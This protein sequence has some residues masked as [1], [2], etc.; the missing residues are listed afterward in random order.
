[1]DFE[2]LSIDSLTDILLQTPIA[3]LTQLC[4]TNK[5]VQEICFSDSFW[6]K[7]LA[8]DFPNEVA[9]KPANLSWKD[10]YINVSEFKIDFLKLEYEDSREEYLLE[11]VIPEIFKQLRI[12]EK[13]SIDPPKI[14]F[15]G[16][17]DSNQTTFER[18]SNHLE[19]GVVSSSKFVALILLRFVR[20]IIDDHQTMLDEDLFSRHYDLGE[21]KRKLITEEEFNKIPIPISEFLELLSHHEDQ[22]LSSFDLSDEFKVKLGYGKNKQVIRK[23][24][25]EVNIWT[26]PRIEQ[27]FSEDI[28]WR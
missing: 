11:K 16:E 21:E 27:A 4:T 17:G 7:R 25:H 24:L 14:Y 18:A 23:R 22:Y 20:I 28:N 10:W 26:L 12:L 2:T 8:Q 13:R 9:K 3:D 5:R 6:Q 15:S 1:M 19:L